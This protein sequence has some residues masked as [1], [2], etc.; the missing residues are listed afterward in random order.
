MAKHTQTQALDQTEANAVHKTNTEALDQLQLGAF[1]RML[2]VLPRHD[3]V[4]YCINR[5]AI[6]CWMQTARHINSYLL[7]Y[8]VHHSQSQH[9][10]PDPVCLLCL[11][12]HDRHQLHDLSHLLPGL[13]LPL[14]QKHRHDHLAPALR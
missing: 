14:P 13:L 9:R 1:I 11:G 12:Y 8:T 6:A 4:C 2:A 10:P 5:A 3:P 7:G